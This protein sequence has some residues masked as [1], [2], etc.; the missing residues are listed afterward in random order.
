MGMGCVGFRTE[1][2]DYRGPRRSRSGAEREQSPHSNG[3][4][5]FTVKGRVWFVYNEVRVKALYMRRMTLP[6]IPW[7]QFNYSEKHLRAAECKARFRLL[8][9]PRS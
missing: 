8:L 5:P 9:I 3:Q 4:R 1:Q 2:K 6:Q 7:K